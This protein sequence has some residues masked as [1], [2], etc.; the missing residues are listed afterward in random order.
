[1]LR[2]ARAAARLIGWC[3]RAMAK[4]HL[5]SVA[6]A[7]HRA[8][9]AELSELEALGLPTDLLK[10]FPDWRRGERGGYRAPP[11]SLTLVPAGAA[12]P[13]GPLRVHLS[14]DSEAVP[15]VLPL[16][17]GLDK[18]LDPGSTITVGIEPGPLAGELRRLATSVVR[19]Q[20]RLLFALLRSAT[21][22]ARDHAL[23]ARSARGEPILLVPRGFR[24]ERGHAAAAI[25]VRAARGALGARIVRSALYW[26]GGN[27]LFDGHQCLIGA[28]L[29]R[30]NM[31][32]LGLTKDEVL[33]TLAAEF[34]TRVHVLGIVSRA[35][36]DSARERLGR[37]GQ[38]S[39]HIDL[40]VCP[41][42]LIGRGPPVALLSDP[43]LGLTLLPR[44]LADPS[45]RNAHGLGTT[46]QRLIARE[47]RR[48]AAHRRPLL[49]R[50]RRQ[51][52]RLGYRVIS[53]PELRLAPNRRL[54]GVD[55]PDFGY[56]NALPALHRGRPALYYL[57]W[58][59]PAL[60]AAAEVAMRR[61]DVLPV[62]LTTFAPL[63]R[64]M[65]RLSAG[66]HCFCGPLP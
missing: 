22:F 30:E 38:A 15:L 61:A 47:Y 19:R 31:A 28:D 8:I 12:R 23:A 41:L 64:G 60:D 3:R 37:S 24:P 59:V 40:D 6:A 48:V 43:D 50:Y 56:C 26:Q 20:R 14:A 25:D 65:M 57:P 45:V 11:R 46:G 44:V 52:E 1:M 51:L 58:G 29:V 35:T 13:M 34:G 27:M 2:Q 7:L 49:A 10:R 9:D 21:T 66:L 63:T 42:G 36:F 16:L 62:R 32:R 18:Q 54:V 53:L 4:A 33:A 55:S 17:H 5:V 39:Y